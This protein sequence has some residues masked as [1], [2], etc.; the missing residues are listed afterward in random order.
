[1]TATP[2]D[3]DSDTDTDHPGCGEQP[4]LSVADHQQRKTRVLARQCTTC[5][6]SPGN[7]MHLAPGQL[8]NMVRQARRD[9]SYIVCHDTLPYGDHPQMPPAI[10]RGF[11]DRYDTQALQI[12][13]RLWGFIE[14]DPPDQQQP[15]HQTAPEA[16]GASHPEQAGGSS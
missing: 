11:F 7:Q 6:F 10:C 15:A 14:V 5:I 12:A 16:G 13:R 2:H 8:A 3:H 9:E 1:M 4:Q